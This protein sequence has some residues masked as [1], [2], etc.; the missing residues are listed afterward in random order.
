MNKKTPEELARE[1]VVPIIQMADKSYRGWWQE[2]GPWSIGRAY[3]DGYQAAKESNS[4]VKPD[5][6]NSSNNSNG[7]ISTK[8]RLPEIGEY[9]LVTHRISQDY[10]GAKVMEARRLNKFEYTVGDGEGLLAEYVDYWMP[11]PAA[12]KEAP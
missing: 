11:L 6:S 5:G 3:I 8:D 7:W 9:V 4:P 2:N 10:D 1:Y 12:P